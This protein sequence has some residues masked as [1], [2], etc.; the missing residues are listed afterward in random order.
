MQNNQYRVS[1]I[2]Y[3]NLT[4]LAKYVDIKDINHLQEAFFLHLEEKELKWDSTKPQQSIEIL[5]SFIME[6]I[7]NQI[8]IAKEHSKLLQEF[9]R[10]LHT[11]VGEEQ[12][13]D[14]ILEFSYRLDRSKKQVEADREAFNRWFDED[15][16]AERIQARVT[17]HQKLAITAIERLSMSHSLLLNFQGV[18][19][20][21]L[22][23]KFQLNDYFSELLKYR[24]E[25][26]LTHASLR[27]FLK[28]IEAFNLKEI[29]QIVQKHLITLLYHIA[30]SKQED[31]WV[32]CDA[33]EAILNLNSDYFIDI[34]TKH[35]KNLDRDDAIFVRH[36]IIKLSMRVAKSKKEV[37]PLLKEYAINDQS[38][39]V[40]QALAGSLLDSDCKEL[41]ELKEII[42]LNDSDKSVKAK[43]ILQILRD[44]ITSNQKKQM[45][46]LIWRAIES[47]R[48]NFVIKT[49]L[50][51]IKELASGRDFNSIDRDFMKYSYKKI[52]KFI[53]DDNSDIS[54]KRY[55]A[56]VREHIW[57]TFNKDNFNLY[58]LLLNWSKTIP[59]SK[60]K[61]MPK[62][63]QN[64][65]PKILY[66]ILSIVAQEDF[67]MQ[68]AYR[69]KKAHLYRG[70]IFKR[71]AWRILF[72]FMH[73]SP[74]KRQ[75]HLHTIGRV[76][77]AR[78]QFPS[79]IMAEQA[80]TKVPGEPYFIPEEEGWRPYIPLLD[81]FLSSL[82]LN[83]DEKKAFLIYTS[84]GVTKIIPPKG[85]ISKLKA[86]WY[87]T[88]N[89]AEIARLRNWREGATE[90]PTAY[91]NEL[92][93]VGF[94]TEFNPY[95]PQDKSTLQFF[96][97]LLPIL[98]PEWQNSL[99]DYFMSGYGNTL[100]D[101]LLFVGG[102][103]GLFFI[104]HIWI[105]DKIKKARQSIPLSV[106]GWGTRGKSG[107]ERLKAALFN[108]LG[109]RV[110]SK[111]TGN[112]AM[113][114]HSENFQPMLETYLYRPYDKAT[115]WEQANV[116]MLASKLEVDIFLWECMGLTPQ[117]V[118]I[119]QKRWMN[120]DI[121][122]I[123]NTYPD[124]ENLQG[125]AGINIP[126]VMTNFIPKNSILI[127]T[128]EVMAPILKDYCQSVNTR[129]HQEGWLR[130]GLIPPDILER[131]PYEEHP[132][133]IAL[134]LGIA[135]E[136]DIDEDEALKMMADFIVPDLGVLKA[137][138]PA[139]IGSKT[140][141]FINGMSANER[142]GALGNWKRMKLGEVD[143]LK[144]PE[145]MVTAVINN[146]ADRVARSRVFASMV[147]ED[148]VADRYIL[149]G[150]NLSGFKSYLEESWNLYK[151]SIL[152]NKDEDIKT[153]LGK[154]IRHYRFIQNEEELKAYTKVMVDT[155]DIKDSIKSDI[156]NN[157]SDEKRVKELLNGYDEVIEFYDEYSQQFNGANELFSQIDKL[158]IEQLNEKLRDYIWRFFNKRIVIVWNFYAKG[159]EI[160]QE[161]YR[162]T[163]PG[164]FNKIIGMQNIKGTGLD[165]AYQW[166]A[167]DS[168]YK[169]CKQLEEE[170]STTFK[171]AI[172]TLAN[173]DFFNFLMIECVSKA[174]E[175]AKHSSLAQND[176]IQAQIRHIQEII[177]KS[178]EQM[179]STN[180]EDEV[181]N[182]T[183]KDIIIEKILY[184]I[185][186]FLDASDAVKRRKTA[187]RIYQDLTQF[188]ISHKKA[189]LELKK[190]VMRQKGGW[191]VKRFKG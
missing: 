12:K 69:F 187:D 145:V 82:D 105:S 6:Y 118:E 150:S 5:Y 36:K 54:L 109:Y 99:I 55:A 129:Y 107:T 162:Q 134:V 108:G 77:K 28:S 52:E 171:Q 165:F 10:E 90:T 147:V 3:S 159:N 88:L 60:S 130:A 141:M 186:G 59:Q 103:F 179:S 95:T 152:L 94:K 65:E 24:E 35:F 11:A 14:I 181:Q 15:A 25:I 166:V 2:L 62:E 85:L 138:P 157:I 175:K 31:V 124:H 64:I 97:A 22:W 40:R 128:E 81:H 120:D 79:T 142:F 80:P 57:L 46:L 102:L 17:R 144:E 13:R 169:L 8:K 110:F 18:S 39:Y 68:L 66:R 156:L 132:N 4:R 93:K 43:A 149:I 155:L 84:D 58:K 16:M 191:F 91:L 170:N 178:K 92:K 63:C 71:K 78:L 23:Q 135:D 104:R 121:S 83:V 114:L 174:I 106:G 67:S 26:R 70:D 176:Y 168:V 51:A 158:N 184:F 180:E 177:D 126:Q 19:N 183:L 154:Y 34:A 47:D 189:S 148:V 48:D 185:E 96:P 112:E 44:D 33:I 131:F 32:Q 151:S 41:D 133:N 115:I 116:V 87:L 74:D 7:Q 20:S 172:D 38:P 100:F 101:L 53:A 29:T 161:I 146:R 164:K 137:Y 173:Y 182:D 72:E 190:I 139:K 56:K 89:F 75:A 42:I 50:Y 45:G 37:I 86:K 167:W 153:Q 160:I 123:T 143:I 27:L 49:A 119:L 61:A 117:Y 76:Y 21:Y 1:N 111:T 30:L 122:T 73:P 98:P 127:S 9:R 188:H 140:L 125:P 163:P 136:L 113:F